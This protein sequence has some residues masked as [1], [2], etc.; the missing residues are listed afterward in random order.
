[1]NGNPVFRFKSTPAFLGVPPNWQNIIGSDESQ[2][3]HGKPH[4]GPILNYHKL[5]SFFAGILSLVFGAILTFQ[6]FKNFSWF[7]I[8]GPLF[9]GMGFLVVYRSSFSESAQ[10]K[11]TYYCLSNQNAY[12]AKFDGQNIFEITKVPITKDTHIQA[13][14]GRSWP[15]SR[16]NLFTTSP[17]TVGDRYASDLPWNFRLGSN[18]DGFR[19]IQNAKHVYNLMRRVQMERAS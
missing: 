18:F 7:I 11:E 8:A 2:L 19:S 12:L 15:L 5:R 17:A 3:W 16:S 9:V 14:L 4:M 6:G 10:R 13:S 1:M